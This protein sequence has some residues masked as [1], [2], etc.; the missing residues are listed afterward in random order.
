MYVSGA[1]NGYKWFDGSTKNF[2][3]IDN[4]TQ[5][6]TVS[7]EGTTNGCTS[8]IDTTIKVWNLPNIEIEASDNTICYK[9]SVQLI[10]KNG[11]SGKYRW[12][13]NGVTA[14]E[15]IVVPNKIVNIVVKG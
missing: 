6:I 10:G 5:E 3:T 9:D 8:K 1:N 7:V 13:H 2:I 4:I 14:D 11:V 15:V 12:S